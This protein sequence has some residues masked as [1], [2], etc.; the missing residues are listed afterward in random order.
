MYVAELG[1]EPRSFCAP[2][3]STTPQ[4]LN[5]CSKAGDLCIAGIFQQGFVYGIEDALDIF[6]SKLSQGTW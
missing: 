6:F 2:A 3:L 4:P 1:F 5:L